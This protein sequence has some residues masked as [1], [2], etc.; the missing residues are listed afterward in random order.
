[1][2]Y[3][4]PLRG[5]FRGTQA[6]NTV[7][8]DG[9]DQ[10]PYARTRSALP[11]AQATFLAHTATDTL[12]ILEGRVESPCYEAIHTR[13]VILVKHRYWLVEDRLESTQSHCYDLRWHLAPGTPAH[14]LHNGIV[15]PALT[16]TILG[17]RSVAL[18]DGW[19]S[20]E[21]GIKHAAPVLSAVAQG[22][23]ARFL[24][25]IAPREPGAPAPTLLQ[26]G[27]T[28]IVGDDRITLP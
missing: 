19:I 21:Y 22:T 6:H 24:T 9:R 5:W 20:P 23:H 7:T 17:A 26:D 11:S 3:A 15:A 28:L 27:D 4:E 13:R 16:L 8:V 1:V 12:D 18:E 14:L 25:L 2:T 10:T